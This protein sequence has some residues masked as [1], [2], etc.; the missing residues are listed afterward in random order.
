MKNM[1]ILSLLTLAFAS[2]CTKKEES[3]TAQ[4][5][6]AAQ[7]TTAQTA[8]SP[9]AASNEPK[10]ESTDTVVGKGAEAVAGKTVFV[11]YKGTLSDGTVF[12]S[13]QDPKSAFSFQ[14]GAGNVIPG[15]E[16]GIP[17][18]KVGG[19]RKLVIPPEMAYGPNGVGKIPPNSTLTFEVELLDVK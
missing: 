7:T 4:N 10:L 1:I 11:L 3:E 19:K 5:T 16:K 9:A 2:A 17:G 13:A 12:D 18:M 8:A 14:L 15:W 6:T